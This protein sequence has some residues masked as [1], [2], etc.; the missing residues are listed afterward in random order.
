MGAVL[1]GDR[2]R[3]ARN[4]YDVGARVWR[5]AAKSLDP[6]PVF[7]KTAPGQWRP[8]A[9]DFPPTP[10]QNPQFRRW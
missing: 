2:K 6:L 4:A 10:S 7:Y 9:H 5:P 8:T 1:M 3:I